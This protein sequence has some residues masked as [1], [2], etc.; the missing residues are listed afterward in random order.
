[1][2]PVNFE[3]LMPNIGPAGSKRDPKKRFGWKKYNKYYDENTITYA[4]KP[5]NKF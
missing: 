1:M 4:R 2:T 5:I 3:G